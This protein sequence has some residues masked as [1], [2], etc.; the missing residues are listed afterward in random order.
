[1]MGSLTFYLIAFFGIISSVVPLFFGIQK[2]S[3][4]S[5]YG[6][7]AIIA[8]AVYAAQAVLGIVFSAIATGGMSLAMLSAGLGFLS[9]TFFGIIV[10]GAICGFLTAFGI[11][12]ASYMIFVQPDGEL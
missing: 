3:S 8:V 1:M 7:V 12:A 2:V 6:D 11:L 9:S 4:A 10:F 5:G